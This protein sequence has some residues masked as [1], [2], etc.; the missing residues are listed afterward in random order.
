MEFVPPVN[1]KNIWTLRFKDRDEMNRIFYE[2]R[3]IDQEARLDG[4]KEYNS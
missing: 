4:I 1:P 3:A 2:N